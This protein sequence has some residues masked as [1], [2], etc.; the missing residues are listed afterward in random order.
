[1]KLKK[2]SKV[3]FRRVGYERIISITSFLGIYFSS[4]EQLSHWKTSK[5]IRKKMDKEID[6]KTCKQMDK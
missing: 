5:L 6:K 4:K 2:P 3:C 1:M